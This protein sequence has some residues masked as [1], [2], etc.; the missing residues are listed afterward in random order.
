MNNFD[1]VE[2][3]QIPRYQNSKVDMSS[4]LGSTR[5]MGVNHSF[6]QE[7]LERP[8]YGIEAKTMVVITEHA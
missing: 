2:I 7:V 1:S 5:S 4:K 8:N 6:V 3:V